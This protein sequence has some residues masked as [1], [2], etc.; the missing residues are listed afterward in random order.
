VTNAADAL[1][2]QAGRAVYGDQIDKLTGQIKG[3]GGQGN[4]RIGDTFNI[5]ISGALDPDR[6]AEQVEKM[7]RKRERSTGRQLLVSRS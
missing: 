1:G 5:N 4:G 6:V 3:K 2:G 7:L